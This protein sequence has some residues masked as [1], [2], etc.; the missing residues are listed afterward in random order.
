MA[1]GDA[2]IIDVVGRE[3]ESDFVAGENADVVLLHLA[4]SIGDQL[5]AVVEGH[6]ETGVRQYLHHYP[7]HF[8]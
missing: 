7:I 2:A 5:V 8:D 6:A 1:E 4:A 3:F